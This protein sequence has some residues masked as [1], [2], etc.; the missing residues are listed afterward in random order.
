MRVYIYARRSK[1]KKGRDGQPVEDEAL[2]LAAQLRA[3]RAECAKRGWEI[4]R[5]LVED[6]KSARYENPTKRV[7]FRE[8]IVDV[9]AGLADVIVVHKLDRFSRNLRLTL[10]SLDRLAQRNVGLVSVVENLDYSTPQGRLSLHMF[11]ALA[12]FYSEN[13]G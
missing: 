10:Q 1:A 4:V 7:L 13:L 5:E 6:D 12:Q 8:M 11:A 9:E 2:S 3:C